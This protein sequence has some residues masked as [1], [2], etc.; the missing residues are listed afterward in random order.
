MFHS[1]SH[2][3]SKLYVPEISLWCVIIAKGCRLFV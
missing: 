1:F 2:I 3:A